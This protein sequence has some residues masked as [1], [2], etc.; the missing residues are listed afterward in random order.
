[1]NHCDN[2]KI[3][4]FFT[5]KQNSMIVLMCLPVKST[6]KLFLPLF[7]ACP[8]SMWTSKDV[9]KLANIESNAASMHYRNYIQMY[10]DF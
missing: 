1:M 9:S 7:G 5:E 8:T 6:S 2:M 3:A 10:A 4:L